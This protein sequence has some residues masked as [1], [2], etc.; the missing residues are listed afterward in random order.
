MSDIE[1]IIIVGAGP[2]GLYLSALLHQ[3]GVGHTLL[4]AGD[5]NMIRG[6]DVILHHQFFTIA[7][8]LGITKSELHTI[9][10]RHEFIMKRT[11]KN[12]MR[13]DMYDEPMNSVRRSNIID[14]LLSRTDEKYIKRN[15][16]IIDVIEHKDYVELKDMGGKIY[17]ARYVIGSDGMNSI[18]RNRLFKRGTVHSVYSALY[19]FV[20]GGPHCSITSC[21]SGGVH[22]VLFPNSDGK[23]VL[24]VATK[25]KC[26]PNISPLENLKNI[27]TD[28]EE[29][30]YL[31]K[32]IDTNANS[33]LTLIRRTNLFKFARG[34]VALIGDAAHGETP[35]LGLGTTMAIADAS[36]INNLLVQA[37]KNKTLSYYQAEKISNK[38]YYDRVN[39]VKQLHR[40]TTMFE[41]IFGFLPPRLDS[42]REK[43]FIIFAPI[44]KMLFRYLRM[45]IRRSMERQ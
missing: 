24:Y 40:L 35:L 4:E 19:F 13:I 21:V 14:V 5:T 28:N 20:N 7:K 45:R 43:F 11:G 8:E 42:I 32:H 17:K 12:I 27:S 9:E 41:Y 30:K 1:N 26:D 3:A 2:G 36:T 16:K 34:R 22:N 31:L 37:F 6:F 44:L 23:S 38:Y 29:V 25:N 15:V 33:L 10:A 18:V 39:K